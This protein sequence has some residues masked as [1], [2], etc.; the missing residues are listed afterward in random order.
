VLIKA[1]ARP[2]VDWDGSK[3]DELGFT[4]LHFAAECGDVAFARLLLHYGANKEARDGLDDYTPLV[5][6]AGNGRVRLVELLLAS[7]ARTNTETLFLGASPLHIAG[8]CAD[9]VKILLAAGASRDVR[10]VDGNTPLDYARWPG[11]DK[12]LR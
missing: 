5:L 9:I 4:P 6:A 1:G 10:D 7:G 8:N 3:N 11:L 2:N 12:L